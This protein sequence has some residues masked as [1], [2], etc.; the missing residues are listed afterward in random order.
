FLGPTAAF[1]AL[2]IILY[3]ARMYTRLWPNRRLGMDDLTATMSMFLMII[4]WALTARAVDFGMGRHN[5]YVSAEDQTRAAHLLFAVQP[6]WAWSVGLGKISMACMLLRIMRSKAWRVFL[7]IIIGIQ[8]VSTTAFMFVVLL[9]C[10]PL[11]GMWAPRASDNCWGPLPTQIALYVNGAVS[12]ITDFIFTFLPLTF[13]SK[14]NLPLRQK[15]VLG[16]LMG[17]GLFA[18]AAGIVKLTLVKT[19]T[20]GGDT[21]Y[22]MVDLYMWG[23][24][25]QEMSIIALCVP[26]LKALFEKILRRLRLV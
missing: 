24:L 16:A 20:N 12:I 4:V 13:I 3:I 23:Y 7:Y 15:V 21:L 11:S 25:E 6:L 5:F 19:Y 14:M 1:L 9:Q 17:M 8:L 18:T 26:C 2:D 10:R 22:K